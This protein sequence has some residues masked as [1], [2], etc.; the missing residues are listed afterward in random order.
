MAV[1]TTPNSNGISV[2]EPLIAIERNAIASPCRSRGVMWCSVDMTI[3]CTA[4]SEKPRSI[5][6]SAISHAEETKG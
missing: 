1:P 4:P 3:G 5:A 2:L 6:H